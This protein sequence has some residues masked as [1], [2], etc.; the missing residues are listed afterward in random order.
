MNGASFGIIHCISVLE[1]IPDPDKAVAAMVAMLKPGG[2]LVMTFPYNEHRYVPNAY[3]IDG[4]YGKGNPFICQ[5]YDR[6]HLNKWIQQN[7]LQ[8]LEQ[9]YCRVFDGEFWSV[10]DRLKTMYESKVDERHHLTGVVLTQR[11]S[12]PTSL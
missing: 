5:M 6:E 8:I 2:M 11:S 3:D 1:H 4:S 7:R 9:R 10:G 12:R